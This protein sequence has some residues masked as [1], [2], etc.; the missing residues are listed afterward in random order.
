MTFR[1]V[2]R[3]S[4]D[5]TVYRKPYTGRNG[6]GDP[7]YGSQVSIA[8]RIERDE[9]KTVTP[10]GNDLLTRHVVFSDSPMFWYDLL[11]LPGD[12]ETNDAEGRI[13]HSI[14]SAIAVDDS[15]TLYEAR[16]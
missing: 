12:D 6:N 3:L 14:E 16:L 9:R 5:K 15:M 4:L 2:K 10:D 8:A 1:T 7:T 11:W 13:V